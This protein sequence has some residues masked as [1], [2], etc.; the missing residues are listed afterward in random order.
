M[1]RYNGISLPPGGIP[2]Q[3]S[4]RRH[5]A[6]GHDEVHLV[7]NPDWLAESGPDESTISAP[8]LRNQATANPTDAGAGTGA[9]P[10]TQ[11]GATSPVLRRPRDA[12]REAMARNRTRPGARRTPVEADLTR[13]ALE[14]DHK[15]TPVVEEQ[16][17]VRDGEE[18]FTVQ[19]PGGP[20]VGNTPDTGPKNEPKPTIGHG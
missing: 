15:G 11:A 18:A 19:T 6:A 10:P 16:P 12:V 4:I 13:R 7:G 2:P 20:V 9:V 8:V 1:P 3:R 17:Q 14:V 5:G